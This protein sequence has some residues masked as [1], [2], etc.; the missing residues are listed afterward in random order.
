MVAIVAIIST[1]IASPNY[2]FFIVVGI[3]K[4]QLLSKFDDS[5]FQWFLISIS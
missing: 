1:S 5:N 2:D 3:I 4:I